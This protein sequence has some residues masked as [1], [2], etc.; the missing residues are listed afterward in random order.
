MAGPDGDAGH[1]HA[2]DL[3]EHRA[4]VIAAAAARP[5]DDQHEVGGQGGAPDLGGQ[6][7]GVVGLDRR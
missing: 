5:G 3:G 1:G 2:A 4:G 7:V 6:R